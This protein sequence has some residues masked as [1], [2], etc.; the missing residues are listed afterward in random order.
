MLTIAT[1]DEVELASKNR[2]KPDP[3]LSPAIPS[4]EDVE[5]AASEPE[6]VPPSEPERDEEDV[7][8]EEEE[9]KPKPQRRKKVVK[10]VWPVGRNGLKKRRVEKTRVTT[11]A[12]G[13]MGTLSFS[14]MVLMA[15]E[16]NADEHSPSTVTPHSIR[17]LF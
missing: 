4:D 15:G 6:P 10:K 16:T 13:Y 9:P 12:K 7:E 14:A 17:D 2:P 1:I 3:K 11:D 5:M 8:M